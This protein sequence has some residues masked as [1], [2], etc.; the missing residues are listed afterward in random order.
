MKNTSWFYS[1]IAVSAL[2][3]SC[4]SNSYQSLESK[5]VVTSSKDHDVLSEPEALLDS[6]SI[7]EKSMHAD[8]QLT[9][10]TANLKMTDTLSPVPEGEVE[11]QTIKV[12]E[13]TLSYSNEPQVT[14]T[15]LARYPLNSENEEAPEQTVG[16]IK[17]S[18][19][20][21]INRD[22]TGW[23]TVEDLSELEDD[24]FHYDLAPIEQLQLLYSIPD[25]VSV[26]QYD[27]LYVL[28]VEASGEELRQMALS[29]NLV[30]QSI[31]NERD[32]ELDEFTVAQ[33]DYMLF[34]NKD[35][36]LLEKTNSTFELL[37]EENDQSWLIRKDISLTRSNVNSQEGIQLP[38]VLK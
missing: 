9:N 19:Q 23:N 25:F 37:L 14:F 31:L 12:T 29:M 33:L 10:Y 1:S 8:N 22:G 17:E 27:D 2:L 6:N 35:T 5:D 7:L 26:S 28:S 32:I 11:E 4:S 20:Y 15:S 16:I 3:A 13:G 21:Q 36:F 30:D 24:V 18:D 38:T 34:I